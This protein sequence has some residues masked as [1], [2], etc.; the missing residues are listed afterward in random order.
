MIVLSPA[1][2]TAAARV[3]RNSEGGGVPTPPIRRR[4]L[5]GGASALAF[6]NSRNLDFSK[7]RNFW[8]LNFPE[9]AP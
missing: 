1:M 5:R 4:P 8:N 3:L 7:F 2:T 9:A 6:R